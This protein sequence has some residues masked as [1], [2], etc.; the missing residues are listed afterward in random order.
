MTQ[1]PTT[2]GQAIAQARK[3][4]G[5][6][7]KELAARIV[8]DEGGNISPQYLN[9]IEHDRRSPSSDHLIRQFAAELGMDDNILFI[10]A[11]KIPDETRRNVKDLMKAADAFM[12]FRRDASN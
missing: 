3:A 10:L 11:G 8:K 6:S 9:D 7:Q 2:F 1:T 12:N 5:L 4:K